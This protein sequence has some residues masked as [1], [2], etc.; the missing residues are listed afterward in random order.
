LYKIGQG[1]SGHAVAEFDDSRYVR[2]GAH[3]R[4][5]VQ[6]SGPVIKRS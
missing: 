1:F 3:M 2:F 4:T 6:L 5:R